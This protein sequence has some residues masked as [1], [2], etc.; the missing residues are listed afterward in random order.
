M[1]M[2]AEQNATIAAT[3]N[4][5]RIPME[6]KKA[7]MLQYGV[8]VQDIAN[9]TGQSLESV[10]GAFAPSGDWGGLH[11]GA[12]G[13]LTGTDWGGPVAQQV[14]RNANL[15]VGP[16]AQPTQPSPVTV[17]GPF[18][19]P[20]QVAPAT[21]VT[22]QARGMTPQQ[23]RDIAAFWEENKANPQ[24][25]KA[26]MTRFGVG[27]TDVMNATGQDLNAVARVF[28][29]GGDW[30]GLHFNQNGSLYGTDWGGPVAQQVQPAPY[31]PPTGGTYY[32]GA[33]P[34]QPGTSSAQPQRP[35]A[36]VAPIPAQNEYQMPVL[37]ALYQ[38]Q[39]QRMTAP[40]PRFN[41]QSQ[42]P[43]TSVAAGPSAQGFAAGEPAPGALTTV[44]NGG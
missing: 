3:W 13:A 20:T 18:A 37:N 23:N 25:L 1:P 21:P 42:G 2:T 7:A 34:V 19:Q 40:A 15:V 9:A 36:P 43:L 4:D 17:V 29:S 26:G 11:F 16:V 22:P 12:N 24:A 38:S 33:N 27:I 6:Q 8:G 5:P 35:P 28:Q 14:Q 32:P 39:Q 31:V 44:I 41:F 10:A 30:G